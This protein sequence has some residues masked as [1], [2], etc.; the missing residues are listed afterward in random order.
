MF[1]HIYQPED[2][3]GDLLLL[4]DLIRWVSWMRNELEL[5]SKLWQFAT[6]ATRSSALPGAR[7]RCQL[8][9]EA[10]L[11]SPTRLRSQITDCG[12]WTLES[13]KLCSWK[14]CSS[15]QSLSPDLNIQEVEWTKTDFSHQNESFNK[16]QLNNSEQNMISWNVM[17]RDGS[18]TNTELKLQSII[19]PIFYICIIE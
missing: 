13:T 11:C 7:F 6:V 18:F 17:N 8:A 4:E 10:E 1:Q 19:T 14:S 2:E 5:L 15:Y 16:Y 3:R 9:S 12:R